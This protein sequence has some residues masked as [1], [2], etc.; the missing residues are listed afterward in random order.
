M[1]AIDA[2]FDEL[3]KRGGSDL[4]L[5]VNQPPL[6][7]VRGELGVLRDAPVLA[8]E[9]EE[10]LLELVTPAQR[11]K[12]AS[13]LDLDVSIPYN[14]AGRFRASLFVKHPGI[15][16]TFRLV[17]MR[18][19]SLSELG[20]PESLW[21]LAD[22]RSGL[23]IVAGPAANGKTTTTA[24]LVDHVNK[25]RAC[26][27]VTIES[28]IE[29]VH[30]PLRAQVSQYEVGAHVP[31]VA[32]ALRQ[33]ARDNADVVFV[34]ELASPEEIEL[35][36]ALAAD[37][38]LVITNMAT[39]GAAASLDRL[40]RSF[41][42]DRQNRCR[43]LLADALAGIIVQHLVRGVD[44]KSRTVVHEIVVGS[45]AVSALVR[46]NDLDALGAILKAGAGGMQSLDG[47]LERLL[48]GGKISPELALE[49]AI[50]KESIARIIARA[51]P[52]ALVDTVLS[53]KR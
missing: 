10:M 27:V 30:E 33:A 32:V 19:P 15:A 41:P 46:E 42:A 21:K 28:P 11:N 23:I 16:A 40:L 5:A 12:L 43:G 13:D 25:T 6:C 45:P 18:V 3:I 29:F 37:G 52:E 35:A 34:S 51:R 7:R 47:G 9:L 20:C 53:E 49:R 50:D 17:P 48:L 1:P 22:R 38:V 8:K 26:H 24:A 4:H 2:L 31:S 14:E 36:L 39:S 44:A